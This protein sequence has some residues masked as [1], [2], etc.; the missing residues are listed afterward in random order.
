[1]GLVPKLKQVTVVTG[2]TRVPL[3]SAGDGLAQ[4]NIVSCAVQPVGSTIYVGDD[5]VSAS[6]QKGIR[7]VPAS[8]GDMVYTLGGGNSLDLAKVYI[9]SSVSGAKANLMFMVR[10]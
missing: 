7:L 4:S 8:T 5:T 2:G 9:D 6:L 1:M 3:L 10:V